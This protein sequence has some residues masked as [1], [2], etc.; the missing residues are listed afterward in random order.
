MS[1]VV[2]PIK[3]FIVMKRQ[4]SNKVHII[5]PDSANKSDTGLFQYTVHDVGPDVK[6]VKL[7]DSL[8]TS[9]GLFKTEVEGEEYYFTREELVCLIVRDEKE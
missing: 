4:L 8:V 1:K 2:I 3:D 9:A 6:T 5:I 7:G